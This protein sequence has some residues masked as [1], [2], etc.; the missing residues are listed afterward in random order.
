MK[1]Y[2]IGLLLIAGNFQYS[3]AQKIQPITPV[4][5]YSDMNYDN[6]IG[7]HEGIILAYMN[8]GGQTYIKGFEQETLSPEF[9][10]KLRFITPKD[11]PIRFLDFVMT[12]EQPVIIG[13]RKDNEL[14]KTIFYAQYMDRTG[15]VMDE[16]HIILSVDLEPSVSQENIH[17]K[18]SENK[19]RIILSYNRKLDKSN[20]I[21]TD[22]VIINPE[23]RV[24]AQ[25]N[26]VKPIRVN[27]GEQ[28]TYNYDVFIGNSNGFVS[29]FEEVITKKGKQVKH[30]TTITSYDEN[31]KE[32]GFTDFGAV[33]EEVFHPYV[34]FLEET[35]MFK[36]SALFVS[37][38]EKEQASNMFQGIFTANF[39]W[40]S[41]EM[42]R[43]E[44]FRFDV[45]TKAIPERAKQME[46][47]QFGKM[48]QITD[49]KQT[50][51]QGFVFFT[52]AITKAVDEASKEG[53][54]SYG[55]EVLW[56]IHK[57]GEIK[58]ML[59]IP[60]SNLS[61]K[62]N[63]YGQEIP[64]FQE[65]LDSWKRHH[66]MNSE[67]IDITTRE[68]KNM[69]IDLNN[70]EQKFSPMVYSIDLKEGVLK[71]FEMDKEELENPYLK[72]LYYYSVFSQSK[73]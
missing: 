27:K 47:K 73:Q 11:Q 4:E 12:N 28:I 45:F 60:H 31:G 57:T 46:V 36:V 71:P 14:N 34:S 17:I 23:L 55:K 1:K 44:L 33:K 8:E 52:Q 53:E 24:T 51:D 42:E 16:E 9:F 72:G 25:V 65:K 63:Y 37:T 50:E 70:T 18:A 35:D 30:L 2:I 13:Y 41:M 3:F 26:L 43:N 22:V 20:E 6:I 56:A 38:N 64:Y 29:S 32:L 5:D 61:F 40:K 7:A 59:E 21:I 15:H 10:E 58:W 39:H 69:V 66:Y 19:E 67:S 49:V 48:F 68:G 54:F 62:S